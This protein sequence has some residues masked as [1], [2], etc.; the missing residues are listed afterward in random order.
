MF[1]QA[2]LDAIVGQRLARAKT[3]VPPGYADLQA[4]AAKLAEIEQAN[5]TERERAEQKAADAEA[6]AEAATQRAKN[7]VLRSAVIATAVAQ[8]AVDPDA[9][10][11]FIDRDKVIIGD[12]DSI[13]GIEEAVKAVLASKPYLVGK[14]QFVPGGADGGPQG[15]PPT[16]YT[17]EQ[18]EQMSKSD[19]GRVAQLF[20]D[21]QLNHL[22]SK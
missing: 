7:A 11:A 3:E 6:R 2:E 13:T 22:V 1:T 19:P 4:K 15:K 8:G 12:D 20:K 18:I 9:V 21:G 5:M 16:S 10:M 17:V 14:P